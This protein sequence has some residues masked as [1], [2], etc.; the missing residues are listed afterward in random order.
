METFLSDQ[1]LPALFIL[2]FLAATLIPL[3]SE[4]LLLVLLSR[5]EIPALAVAVATC[6]NT[7]GALT[8]YLIGFY[9]GP[10]LAERVLRIDAAARQRAEA[11]YARWGSWSLL[12]SWVPILGDPLCLVGGV[13][14]VPAGRFVLLVGSGKLLRYAALALLAAPALTPG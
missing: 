12:L 10:L 9:G 11:R 4:W 6:G 7:L 13:L 2:S 5:G 1:G 8:T 14:R 3:G